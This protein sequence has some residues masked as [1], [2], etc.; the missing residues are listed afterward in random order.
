M[1]VRRS[2]VWDDTAG[3]TR[4]TLVSVS[5][6]SAAAIQAALAAASNAGIDVFWEGTLT[7]VASAPA[8]ATFSGVADYASLR[9]ADALGAEAQL[10]LPAPKLA[11]FQADQQ[12]VDPANAAIAA[13]NAVVIG[14]LVT[15]GGLNVTTFLGGL[16]RR[17]RRDFP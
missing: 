7:P 17:D 9:Y 6:A 11:I 15:A 13:L 16:R 14:N 2:I 3:K 4:Q 5:I 1:T 12:T 8:A 10:T